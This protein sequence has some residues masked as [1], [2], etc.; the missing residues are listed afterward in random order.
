M[1]VQELNLDILPNTITNRRKSN[2]MF[3]NNDIFE[4]FE[5]IHD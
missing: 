4:V 5:S 3:I 1:K 2:E